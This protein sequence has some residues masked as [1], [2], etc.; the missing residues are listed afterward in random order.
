MLCYPK[1]IVPGD[2]GALIAQSRR[3]SGL[4][5]VPFIEIGEQRKILTVYWTSRV[6]R[7]GEEEEDEHTI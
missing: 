2:R 1:Q 5:C 7:Y 4:L 6:E 3:G